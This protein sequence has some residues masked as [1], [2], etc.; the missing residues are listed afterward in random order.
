ML[1]IT[2]RK[3]SEMEK[4]RL[5]IQLRQAQK[6]EAIG[7]LAAGIAHEINTPT[8]FIGDNTIFLRD[9]F[10]DILPLIQEQGRLLKEGSEATPDLI[11]TLRELSRGLDLD[12]CVTEIPRAIDQML[13]GIS[14]VARIVG[15]MKDFSHPGSESKMPVDLNHSIESTL[16][17][18]RN[19]WKYF[20]DLETEY[21]PDLPLVPCFPSEFNQVIL[22]LVI[23][24][25]HAIQEAKDHGN[26]ELK[27]RIRV[28]T[29]HIGNEAVIRVEDNGTGIPEAIRQRIFEPFFTTKPIGK[30]TG[31]GL[32][33][34]RGVIV[35]KHHGRLDLESELGRGT[36]FTISL[37]M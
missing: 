31:Q 24:A 3:R 17:I 14:R 21:D 1:D 27:G 33:I 6:L 12:Y 16:I 20:A 13:D 25:A 22:N 18:S 4:A 15:A 34:A 19:E 37:P 10:R 2:D 30:G 23:N 26:S 5:E 11:P 35:D 7:Q 32:A 9:A 36:T 28:S 8:Q 29:C